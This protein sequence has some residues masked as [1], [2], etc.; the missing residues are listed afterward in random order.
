MEGPKIGIVTADITT[1]ACDAIVN[2]ANNSLL[3]GEAYMMPKRGS[4]T[5]L[6]R[7]SAP[8]CTA[9]PK[10][11]AARIVK[12]FSKNPQRSKRSLSFV[13]RTKTKYIIPA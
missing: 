11:E 7:A 12:C 1:L 4:G 6:F 10:D 9:T 13:S 3:A 8:E 2:T 5:S